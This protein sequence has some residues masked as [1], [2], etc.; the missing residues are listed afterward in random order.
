[1]HKAWVAN[2]EAGA[3]LP[4]R[5]IEGLTREQLLAHPIP[6]TW[7]IQQ[8]VIHLLDSDVIASDRMKRIIAEDRPLIIA[9]NETRFTERLFYDELNAAEAAEMFRLNR[10]LTSEILRRLPAEAFDRVGIHNEIGLVTLAD[11]VQK[12]HDH[13]HHHL[14]HLYRKREMLL[15]AAPAK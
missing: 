12:Y 6:G 3:D 5:A 9:Y 10:R 13:L 14:R 7:S 4:A 15:G 8:I 11:Q 2:Y 1:M